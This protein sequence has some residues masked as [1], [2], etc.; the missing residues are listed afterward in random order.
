MNVALQ[1]A[2]AAGAAVIVDKFKDSIVLDAVIQ[3]PG[4]TLL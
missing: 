3:W 2:R 4:G 1:P